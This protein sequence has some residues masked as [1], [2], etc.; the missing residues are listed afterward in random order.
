MGKRRK[1]HIF[2]EQV[3]YIINY[4]FNKAQKTFDKYDKILT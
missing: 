4:L 1:D 3:Y 2:I